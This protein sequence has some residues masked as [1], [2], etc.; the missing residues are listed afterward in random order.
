M[1]MVYMFGVM[2]IDMKVNG[3][4]VSDMGMDLIFSQMEIN[5]LVSIH[6][7]IQT[8]TDNTNGR[9][10]ISI[11]ELLKMVRNVVRGNGGKRC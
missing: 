8:V 1:A 10:G 11:L 6:M 3:R 7:G 9:M 2:G 5:L 4:L